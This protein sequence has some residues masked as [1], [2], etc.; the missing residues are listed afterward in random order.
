MA[1]INQSLL[2]QEPVTLQAF[3]QKDDRQILYLHVGKTGGTT[4]NSVLRSNCGWLE[5]AKVKREC[6]A[7]LPKVESV[8]SHLTRKTIHVRYRPPDV[9]FTKENATSFLFTVRNP[10]S[11]VVSAFNMEHLMNCKQKDLY[12][13]HMKGIF[14]KKCFPTIED[15]AETLSI[16]VRFSETK[17]VTVQDFHNPNITDVIDCYDLGRNTLLGKGHI[18]HVSHLNN[19][20]GWYASKTILKYPEKKFLLYGQKIYGM[21]LKN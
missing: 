21:M 2:G 17:N 4:L 13:T 1:A 6:L 5:G 8:I 12:A 20:Y 19:N 15:L 10:V 14:Y 3:N 9:E 11:W 18:L 7:R 16:K